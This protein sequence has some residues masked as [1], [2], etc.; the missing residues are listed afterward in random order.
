[1]LLLCRLLARLVFPFQT[2][3]VPEAGPDYLALCYYAKWDP[4][5]ARMLT[6]E[7]FP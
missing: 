3:V 7:W 6:E 5:G 4:K 1:M 2:S